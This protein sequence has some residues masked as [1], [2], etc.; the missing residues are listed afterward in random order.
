MSSSIPERPSLVQDQ[1]DFGRFG[2][3]TRAIERADLDGRSEEEA[4]EWRLLE[5][6]IERCKRGSFD[7]VERL[8]PLF[9]H[10]PRWPIKGVAARVLGHAGSAA[11]FEELRAALAAIPVWELERIDVPVRETFLEACRALMAWGRLDVVPV[12]LDIYL[13]LQLR[14]AA[15]LAIIPLLLGELLVDEKGSIL[16]LGPPEVPLE[17][18]CD[19]V[20]AEH[21]RVV[22]RVGSD[23]A[24]VY[25]GQLRS[26]RDLAERMKGRMLPYAGVQLRT[27]RQIFEPATGMDCS[28]IFAGRSR[29]TVV[30]MEAAN[31]L[32][33]RFLASTAAADYAP[34][35]RTFFGHRVPD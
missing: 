33:D 6:V 5:R 35:V 31:E 20:L 1:L 24:I 28:A 7:E 10:S 30:S 3:F 25:R 34:G 23:Q 18:Y 27:L 14:G 22:A 16:S 13:T 8:L 29:P 32:A 19:L 4:A 12:L 11:H 15:E 17:E 2:Y 21:R 9:L 26:V